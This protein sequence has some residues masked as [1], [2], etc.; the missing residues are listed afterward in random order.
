MRRMLARLWRGMRWFVGG[1]FRGLDAG[2]R[3]VLNLLLLAAVGGAV[4]AVVVAFTTKVEPHTVL[5]IAPDGPMSEEKPKQA[6]A[7]LTQQLGKDGGSGILLRDW[8]KALEEAAR[9]DRID[10]VLL[11]LDRFE[12]AGL[13]TLREAAAAMVG[14]K[15]SGKPIIAWGSS[16]D[17][18]QYYLAAHASK[19]YLHPM[20]YVLVRGLGS[21]RNYYKDALDR[22][23]IN[24]HLLRVGKYKSAGEPFVASAP[25]KESLEADAHL[26]DALWRLYTEGVENARQLPPGSVTGQIDALP[27]ALTDVGGDAA[28]LALESHWVD[29]LKT[30]DEIRQLLMTEVGKDDKGVSFRRVTLE[31]YVDD[32]DKTVHG[33]HVAIIVAQGEI[34]DQE[35]PAGR[36]GGLSTAKLIRKVGEDTAAR[37]IVLRVNSPGG[38]VL[39]SELVRHE[40]ALTRATGKPVVVS[41][42]DVAASGGYWISLAADRVIAEP[43]TITGS[44]GVFGLIPT[45]EGLMGKLSIN[46]GGYRT[47]WLAGMP[48]LRRPLDPR[49][50]ALV[51]SSI[52]HTYG[53][54]VAKVAAARK[55]DAAQ[56]EAVAQGRVWTG[57]QALEHKLVDQVGSL[58]DAVKAARELVQRTAGGEAGAGDKALPIR[59]ASPQ[60]TW[61]EA[62]MDLVSGGISARIAA[63][64]AAERDP[65]LAA[66]AG[67]LPPDV[68]SDLVWLRSLVEG[69]KP[70]ETAAHCLCQGM[71]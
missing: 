57:Q 33:D 45:A 17:Q 14:F 13:A 59:Y 21:E 28:R 34:S 9:D 23:G 46:T 64:A 41:M 8:V 22:L 48:D 67:P 42:G 24:V 71:L 3:F 47:T 25:S 7:F 52:E 58:G 35:A 16:F 4:F 37:A 60:S 65:V 56:V 69:R 38:S 51:Q 68:V 2:R 44:I 54:F 12:G 29:G 61:R 49:F 63:A 66:A 5:V 39:G 26:Y 6:T 18:R 27:G 31:A 10:Y 20:G 19:V 43:S 62:L 11:N 70:F 40:L 32:V 50:E 1:V 53:D 36:I 55:L 15:N 30:F